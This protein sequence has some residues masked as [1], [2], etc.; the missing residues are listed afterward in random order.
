MA[1]GEAEVRHCNRN[2]G[3]ERGECRRALCRKTIRIRLAVTE[4]SRVAIENSY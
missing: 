2:R 1:L 3:S 4:A